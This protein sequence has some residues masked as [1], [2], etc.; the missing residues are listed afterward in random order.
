MKLGDIV[1]LH[2]DGLFCGH[3]RMGKVIETVVDEDKLVRKVKV[4][5]G[6]K[7]LSGDGKRLSEPSVLERPIHKLTVLVKVYKLIDC[8]TFNNVKFPLENQNDFGRDCK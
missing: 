1:V 2:D 3:W 4:L 5:I 6:D 7:H 8:F